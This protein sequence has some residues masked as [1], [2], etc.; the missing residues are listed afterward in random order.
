MDQVGCAPACSGLTSSSLSAVAAAERPARRGQ[1]DLGH[2][3]GGAAAQALRHR[4]VLG[5]DGHDLARLGGLEHQRA[6]RD[7]RLL[8]GQGET[9]AGGE[10]RQ[11]G[12]QPQRADQGVEHH[13][14]LGVLDQPGDGVGPGIGD[15]ADL[16]GRGVVGDGDVR[17]ARLGALLGEQAG[18]AAARRQP[19]D[20]EAVRVG[21]D[22]VQRLGAD[23]A[24]AAE[25]QHSDTADPRVASLLPAD[26]HR[27]IV[28]CE[29]A[30]Q[31]CRAI[32]TQ[33]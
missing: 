12:L 25:N 11:R 19:D 17:H 1:H 4:G 29:S 33:L 8:V 2:L 27:P 16:G 21:G 5:V 6:A 9:G 20:L 10:R 14:G 31:R 24:G 23:R 13:V 30:A 26:A 7:Q 32:L 28:P 3:V 18:I 15:V 22:D